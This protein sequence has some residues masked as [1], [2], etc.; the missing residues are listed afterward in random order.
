MDPPAPATSRRAAACTARSAAYPALQAGRHRRLP[1][2]TASC[3]TLRASRRAE[4]TLPLHLLTR[5]LVTHRSCAAAR[6]EGVSCSAHPTHQLHL[7]HLPT[8]M[9]PTPA[10]SNLVRNAVGYSDGCDRS[11]SGDA[12]HIP[13]ERVCTDQGW[14]RLGES[15]PGTCSLRG[16]R[17]T[18]TTASASDNSY[19]SH[20]FGCTSGTVRPQFAPRLI[21][22]RPGARPLLDRDGAAPA[23]DDWASCTD[24]STPSERARRRSRGRV[25]TAPA[26]APTA[27]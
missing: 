18:P 15:N 13:D 3:S 1:W 10:R 27:G 11:D 14:S 16:D 9:H 7:H 22:R 25:G 5:H 20:T 2:R 17:T 6:A 12:R 19:R 26:P 4:P 23:T 21:P 24:S 8:V